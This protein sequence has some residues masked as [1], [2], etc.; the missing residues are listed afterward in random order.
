[1]YNISMLRSKIAY[2]LTSPGQLALP[3]TIVLSKGE[4]DSVK[5]QLNRENGKYVD[6][7]YGVY[8][9]SLGM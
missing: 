7:T 6:R 8:I 1:M 4:F 5:H 9:C 3:F 2:C